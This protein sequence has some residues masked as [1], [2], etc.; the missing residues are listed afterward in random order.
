ML[1]PEP[2]VYRETGGKDGGGTTVT[3]YGKKLLENYAI[4]KREHT[5]FLERLAELTDIQSGTFKTIGR[6]GLADIGTQSDAG[7]RD[8]C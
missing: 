2:I 5:H 6:L 8:S 3:S 7:N 1:S 4:L